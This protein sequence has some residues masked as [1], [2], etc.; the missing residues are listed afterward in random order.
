M[1]RAVS[2][3]LGALFLISPALGQEVVSRSATPPLLIGR[4]VL[5]V[6]PDTNG[7]QFPHLQPIRTDVITQD[8]GRHIATQANISAFGFACTQSVQAEK[9]PGALAVLTISAP[10]HPNG[11]VQIKHASLSFQQTL[12]LTGEAHVTLPLL[13]QDAEI[14]TV[15][16]EKT[17][18]TALRAPE[19]SRFARVAVSWDKPGAQIDVRAPR[20]LP[21]ER[22]LVGTAD[23]PQLEIISHPLDPQ[24][25]SGV[26]R[27]SVSRETCDQTM[28]EVLRVISGHREARYSLLLTEEACKLGT[29]RLKTI[30][31]DLKLATYQ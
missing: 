27:L 22:Y 4:D 9:Q 6:L 17:V 14:E 23:G 30:L 10:C 31:P 5:P 11:T 16:P 3:L 29:A 20:H 15:F 8:H 26:I 2:V 25:R 28:G 21:T 13:S 18:K 1:I 24:T 7:V 12:S 19:L